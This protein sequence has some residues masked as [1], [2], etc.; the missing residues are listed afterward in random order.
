MENR[1]LIKYLQQDI[2]EKQRIISDL[3]LK[4][5]NQDNLEWPYSP[6]MKER[7]S[8]YIKLRDACYQL[9]KS[10]RKLIYE[11]KQR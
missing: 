3:C 6:S 10:H 2:D 8:T 1:K 9:C 11:L 5:Y 4:I 7:L